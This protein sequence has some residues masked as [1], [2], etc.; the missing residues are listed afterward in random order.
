VAVLREGVVTCFSTL[1]LEKVRQNSDCPGSTVGE[2]EEQ[3]DLDE[4]PWAMYCGLQIPQEEC[5]GSRA[6]GPASTLSWGRVCGYTMGSFRVM[7]RPG[8][9][10]Q[11]ILFSGEAT[12]HDST[13][14][15]RDGFGGEQMLGLRKGHYRWRGRFGL[16]PACRNITA[17]ND[18]GLFSAFLRLIMADNVWLVSGRMTYLELCVKGAS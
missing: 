14:G 11:I 6:H 2:T 1:D 8:A 15:Y 9:E 12:F 5:L 17:Y 13:M 10:L 3:F 16:N 18:C 4:A 7:G